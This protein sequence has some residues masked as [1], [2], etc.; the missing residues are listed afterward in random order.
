MAS[1]PDPAWP[2]RPLTAWGSRVRGHLLAAY[3][4]VTMV[5]FFL[6]SCR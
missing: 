3:A 2:G 6:S 4:A 5:F 1:L